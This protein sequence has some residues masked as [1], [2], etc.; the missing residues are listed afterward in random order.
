[1]TRKKLIKAILETVFFFSFTIFLYVIAMQIA[2]PESVNWTAFYWTQ[3]LRM[4]M[5]GEIAFILA[6]VSFFLLRYAFKE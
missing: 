6:I 4:D 5:F 3:W 2:H 1:L